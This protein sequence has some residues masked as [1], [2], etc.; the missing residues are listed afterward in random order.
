MNE[1]I[2][3]FL[4]GRKLKKLIKST[5]SDVR[6]IYNV[7]QIELE[8]LLYLNNHPDAVASE[9]NRAL[10]LNKG[11]VSTALFDLGRKNFIIARTNRK[12]RRFTDYLMTEKGQE[13]ITEVI[14]IRTGFYDRLF[15]GVS[16]NDKEVL[17]RV[18]EQ[19]NRNMEHLV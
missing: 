1:D 3:R 6:K 9:I 13:L 7:N 18:T 5:Y 14:R 16:E 19:I 2:I 17:R 15:A 12:D 11:Q 10:G 4:R 8:L